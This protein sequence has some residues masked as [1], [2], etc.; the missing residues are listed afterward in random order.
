MKLSKQQRKVYD[1][2]SAHERATAREII[3]NCG[4]NYPSSLVRDLRKKGAKILTIPGKEYDTYQLG[5]L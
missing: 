2:L 3:Y 5:A 1:Y 4:T